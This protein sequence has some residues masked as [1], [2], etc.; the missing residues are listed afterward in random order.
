MANVISVA[1]QKGGV[2]KSTTVQALGSVLQKEGYR[3][4]II[5]M[6]SQAN[7]SWAAGVDEPKLT[8]SNVLEGSCTT[9]Q[10]IIKRKNYDI[11]PSNESLTNVEMAAVKPTL[12]RDRLA[13][14]QEEYDY[15]LIDTPPALGNLLFNSLV[16]SDH[17][18]ITTE[19]STYA[20]RGLT[21]LHKTVLNVRKSLNKPLN[22]L[23][24]VLIKYNERSVLNRE[25][26]SMLQEFTLSAGTTLFETYIRESIVVK[27][28]QTVREDLCDY[29]PKSKPQQ[30]YDKLAAEVIERSK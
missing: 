23:G 30:D 26:K 10:A 19:A 18:I 29:A 27:E 22:I 8:I 5:D 13:S 7:L 15:I 20:L 25:L 17:L 12:L 4:L 28:A 11:I 24:V 2:G 6:D 16:A 21:Q 3:V 9:K 14:V 1:L